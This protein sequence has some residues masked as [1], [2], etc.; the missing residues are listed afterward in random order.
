MVLLLLPTSRASAAQEQ[1][2]MEQSPSRQVP[3]LIRFAASLPS[4]AGEGVVVRFSV[5]RTQTAEVPLWREEQRVE[6]DLD[7]QF[8]VLLGAGSAA[9]LP[10]ELFAA[11]E[12]HW[13]GVQVGDGEEVRTLLTS[14]PYAMKA[15]DAD[16][17]AG[18]PAVSFVTQQQL[19][20]RLG[21][22]AAAPASETAQPLL[23]GAVTGAGTPNVLPLWTSASVLGDSA[24]SQTGSGATAKVGIAINAPTT[25]LDV[26]GAS[27]LRAKVNLLGAAATAAAGHGSPILQFS[28]S[29]FQSGASA[30]PQNFQWQAQPTG[31]NTAT[32]SAALRLLF[33]AG[34]TVPKVTGL[35]IAP[36]GVITFAPGQ[37]FPSSATIFPKGAT[38]NAE[39]YINGSSTDWMLVTTNSGGGKGAILGQA[40]GTSTGIEG[41][42]PG[43]IGVEGVSDTGSGVFAVSNTTGIALQA[44]ANGTG[45][46]GT[47]YAQSGTTSAQAVNTGT[48]SA[49][50]ASAATGY[51]GY[52]TN[53]AT[54]SAT[55][56]AS[57]AGNGNAGSFNN[58]S[59][60]RV[61]L[62]GTNASTDGSAIGTY[63]NA[64]NGIAVFGISSAGSG[65]YGTSTSGIGTIGTS[66]S[67]FG[68][69]GVSTSGTG[70]FGK[71]GTISNTGASFIARFSS[72]VFGDAG[73]GS[74]ALA[75]VSGTA[76]DN[77]AGTFY[78]NSATY[79]PVY[80]FNY[81][82]GG[83]Q[84]VLNL[85]QASSPAGTCGF[86]GAGNLSCTGQLKS[87]VDAAGG[88][89]KVETYAVQAAENWLEDYGS[90]RL[91]NGSATIVLEPAFAGTVNAG[92]EY[93]VFLTPN[94]DCKGLYVDH[95]TAASFEVHELGGGRAQIAFDYK[96]VAKRLGH[97]TERLVDVTEQ[98]RTEVEAARPKP[99][100]MRPVSVVSA[101]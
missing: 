78:N 16:T 85:F 29:S 47:F 30:V 91:T 65:V 89:R 39:S 95:K 42:S 13:I 8:T 20:A 70:V 57:N 33:G 96:I 62:A 87:L 46:A 92:V 48:G 71:T 27:T 58:N 50:S 41:A 76:D 15:A 31:N 45:P 66:A 24:L 34:S 86:G 4:H 11:G 35:S 99:V 9:G 38:F 69:N 26:N 12:P 68:V 75:G 59:A 5:Y 90:G 36:T 81:N 55:V 94:A 14:V 18:L 77:A 7:G 49:L 44:V 51:G 74:T 53:N 80:T 23:A 72:G 28:A 100:K 84:A 1:P 60:S 82:L 52:F 56:Y 22:A 54:F 83:P 21:A 40:V 63:G 64:P 97:E 43:G 25:T 19:A 3:N 6:T 10:R 98:L 61:A 101:P 67:S 73:Q 79:A 93:H 88:T 37:S 17:L 32:P 2:T